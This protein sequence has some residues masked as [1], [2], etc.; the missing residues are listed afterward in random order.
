M[1]V[2]LQNV[3]VDVVRRFILPKLK[4]A[5]IEAIERQVEI[6]EQPSPPP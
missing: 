6:E 3:F 5:A 2:T 1:Q 4:Y